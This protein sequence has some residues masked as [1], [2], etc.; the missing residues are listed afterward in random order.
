MHNL[1]F[2][3]FLKINRERTNRSLGWSVVCLLFLAIGQM[4]LAQQHVVVP[5]SVENVNGPNAWNFFNNGNQVLQ[6]LID[7]SQLTNFIGQEIGSISFRLPGTSTS[8]YPAFE[9]WPLSTFT[10]ANFDIYLSQGVS[11]SNITNTFA[12]NVVGTQTQVR[13]GELIIDQESYPIGDPADFGPLITFN[14]P[15][16]YSGGIL[17]LE[18]RHSGSDYSVSFNAVNAVPSSNPNVKTVISLDGPFEATTGLVSTYNTPI[19]RFTEAGPPIT[20]P[21]VTPLTTSNAT[22]TSVDVS[23]TAGGTETLWDI[24]WGTETFNPN[25]NTGTAEG[26]QNGLTAPNYSITGLTPNTN[27]R[28]FV[29]ADCGD[30]D[31]SPWRSVAFRSGY[32]VP[33]GLITSSIYYVSA[34]STT[35]ANID[36]NYSATSGVGYVDETNTSFSVSPGL[37][38]DWSISASSAN[39]YFYI[40]V[41]WNNNFIFEPS[42]RIYFSNT[43]LSSPTAGTYTVD[44]MQ[45]PGTYRM[46]IAN[47]YVTSTLNP[48]GPS[49]YGNFVDFNINVGPPPTCMPVT[50]INTSNTTFTSVDVAWT[51]G[52][53]ETLW[54]IQWGTGTFNPNTNTGTAEGSQNGLTAPNYTITGLTPNTDYKIW[55]RAD[56][57]NGDTSVWMSINFRSGYCVP[58]GLTTSTTYYVAAFSTTNANIDL[59]YSATS[60]VGYVDETGTPFSV[61]P[62]ASFDWSISASASTNRFYIWIDLNGNMEFEAS[63][64]IYASTGYQSSPTTGTYTIDPMQTPGIYRMRVASGWVSVSG[65]CSSSTYG[66]FVDFNIIVGPSP[67]CLPITA[68]STS[69]A[70]FTSVDV[71]WTTG[72]TETL[73]DIQ[74]GTGTFNPNTNTGTA[75]GSQNGL[76]APNYTITGLT[77][78][79]DYK[80]WVRADCGSGDTSLWKSIHFRSGYC[81]PTGLTT[82]STYYINSFTTTNANI[83]LN[84]SA[85]SGVGYVDATG[86]VFSVSPGL[87]FDWSISASSST[88][89]F[90]VWIDLNGNMEFEP[91]ELIYT[92]T[93]LQSSP[94]TGTYTVDPMQAP[95]T[96]RMRIYN[97]YL[98]GAT[99]TPC[100]PNTYG[101]YVDF[102]VIVGPPQ[103]HH[104]ISNT[105]QVALHQTQEQQSLR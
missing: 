45:A 93:F 10:Y 101:N 28:V 32:C 86:E 46:R 63:E 98:S 12:N 48:C 31:T 38:F 26:S 11:F 27:Y 40:W 68:L 69:N 34:F 3:D 81:V 4:S 20:C 15:Y 44:P 57:G 91:S 52:G 66:N 36:L 104:L 60:G 89:Y 54:D 88:N 30:G 76:T 99:T 96:Y 73:W 105:D 75:E 49:T 95:G 1:T 83:D 21:Q 62:G 37:P 13:S 33:S 85:T 23:W 56:C 25:T 70:T 5:N 7:E 8:L 67:T 51:P 2:Y 79:T 50:A 55:V 71:S 9:P 84:Y 19:V 74:W 39:N 29:R 43:L 87:S 24:Q 16:L 65:P 97:A 64:L 100:G 103:E 58:T 41:D 59:N 78:D 90:Y 53:T 80:I 72:G 17:L 61:S 35:N 6:L 42:E 82:S 94:V 102:N 22:F 14:T 47:S 92:S 77:S 18:V